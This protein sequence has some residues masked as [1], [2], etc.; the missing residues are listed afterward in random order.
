MESRTGITIGIEDIVLANL[1][2]LGNPSTTNT[3]PGQSMS[4]KTFLSTRKTIR[5]FFKFFCSW[6]KSIGPSLMNVKWLLPWKNHKYTLILCRILELDI[7]LWKNIKELINIVR[8]CWRFVTDKL[9][10]SQ[11]YKQKH[12]HFI[13]LGC[14]YLNRKIGKKLNQI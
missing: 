12:I 14:M 3:E 9:I 4:R 6:L 10:R 7:W 5:E 2:N 11:L 1:K 8:I 13:F